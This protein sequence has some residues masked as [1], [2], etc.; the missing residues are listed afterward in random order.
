MMTCA[1]LASRRDGFSMIEMMIVLV[2]IAIIAGAAAPGYGR[3]MRH[4]R[5]NEAASVVASDLQ[6][7][8]SLAARQRKPVRLAVTSGEKQFTIK[9]RN[10]STTLRTR[11]LGSDSN[12]GLT[13]LSFYPST[14]DIYPTGI[15]S[16]A[17]TVTL[18]SKDYSR[19][20]TAST[21]GFVRVVPA[22]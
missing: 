16:A 8:F 17:L 10:A 18:T 20:V 5:V 1:R 12:F 21:G 15:S 7:A 3:Y 2:I 6:M 11:E 22:S 4:Q 9:D 19:T 14:I 13:A